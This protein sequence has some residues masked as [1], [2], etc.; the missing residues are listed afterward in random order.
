MR[1]AQGLLI[2]TL[3]SQCSFGPAL[4]TA[5]R[6]G[7]TEQLINAYAPRDATC[8]TVPLVRP[9]TN[10]STLENQ[11][12]NARKTKAN[13]A[14]AAWL[15][16]VNA[17]FSTSILPVLGLT[18]SGGGYRALLNAAGNMQAMDSRDSNSSIG[19]LY[20][21]ITYQTALSGGAWFL[22][23]LAASNWATVSLLQKTIYDS[24][25]PAGLLFPVEPNVFSIVPN[26]AQIVADI[27]AKQAAGSPVT[28]VDVY[29]RLLGYNLFNSSDGGVD[30]TMSGLTSMSN[31]S[32]HSVPY[33]ILTSI[34]TD[35]NSTC[36]V[37]L[38]ATQFEFSP[39]EFGSWDSG[40]NAFVQT[41]YLS[42]N[43]TNGMAIS[44]KCTTGLD[45][46]GFITGT[47]SD[48]FAGA[49]DSQFVPTGM[50]NALAAA[51]Q[52]VVVKAAGTGGDELLATYRNPFYGSSHSP[53]V[54]HS[55]DLYLADGGASFQIQPIWPLIQPLRNVSVLIVGDCYGNTSSYYPGNISISYT[56]AQAQANNLVKMPFIP[57]SA[58]FIAQNLTSRTQF[59]GCDE[60]DTVTIVWLPLVP[61]IKT[62]S[63]VDWYDLQVSEDDIASVITNGNL[64]ATQGNDEEWPLCLACAFMKKTGPIL[65][66]GCVACF[67]K[68]CYAPTA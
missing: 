59:F 33:P 6:P 57:T 41:A 27:G 60:P 50:L 49:C 26:Y 14:L 16:K 29:G 18:H 61:Y 58:V 13:A 30:H 8:P 54:S 64:V 42:S 3:L 9:A 45:N 65:P 56:Y 39:Y 32:S 62:A 2:L 17:G 11:Y 34:G 55:E 47:S 43:L 5:V 7:T 1:L 10:I 22:S 52:S 12:I 68:Y 37:S 4:A 15:K 67:T 36:T 35:S 21:A 53:L 38:N 31:F 46:L 40:T 28:L 20:Q 66:S 44:K 24:T 48:F 51:L 19:G 25:I 63:N 23:S